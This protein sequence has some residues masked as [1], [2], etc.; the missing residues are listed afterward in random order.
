MEPRLQPGFPPIAE[1]DQTGAWT[2]YIYANGRKI[3]RV[4]PTTHRIHVHGT[5]VQS[6]YELVV[7]I[8]PPANFVV[9]PG[10]TV[11][12]QQFDGGDV[13][14]INL[15]FSSTQTAWHSQDYAGEDFNQDFD[16]GGWY[17]RCGSLN[18]FVGQT[19]V[20]AQVNKDVATQPGTWDMLIADWSIFRVDGT[21][22]PIF[23][24][25]NP[26]AG[27]MAVD[28]DYDTAFTAAVEDS[29]AATDPL[30]PPASSAWAATHFYTGDHLGT[31]QLE[32]SSGGWPVWQ[33]HFAPYGQELLSGGAPLAPDLP[34]GSNNHYKFTGK[35]RDAESGLDN[36]ISRYYGSN[37]GRFMSPDDG[38][39]Q[40]TVNP[41]SWNLYSYGRN[42]PL[43]GID[44]DGHTYN[45]CSADGK[46][47]SNVS[48][49]DF[50]ADQKKDQA[51][52]VNFSK[53]TITDSNG[54]KQGSYTHDPDIAGDPATNIAAMGRIA[55]DGNGAIK[56]FVVG[57]V[58][59]GGTAGVGL[60]ASGAGAGLTTLGDLS[61]NILT[62]QQAGAIIGW[63]TGQ[64][65]AG[66]LA[67]QELAANLTAEDVAGM[68]AKG[69]NPA[70]AQKL[71]NVYERAVT[72]G[73]AGG[74]AMARR[75]LM[76]KI[77]Q[78]MGK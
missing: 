16:Q 35:E 74:Q 42:N 27:L 1:R 46:S 51:N 13:G 57:S 28:T 44:A 24:A 11:C 2:D 59:I 50:E 17:S 18:D 62:N 34:D 26:I 47:C 22:V 37:M 60:Y 30:A 21:V 10:D 52:G 77:V 45:V 31:A 58:A 68:E 25:G 53:G 4:A 15:G 14:G 48:D 6:G 3:A 66:V 12:W 7:S 33:G 43:I 69:L 61:L 73:K 71:L 5:T 65:E 56:A 36:F 63:G 20:Y 64:A 9:Q 55:R 29:P 49:K 72:A 67:T 8:Q 32:L 40:D 41:Q 54:V 39:D 23:T 70:T 19:M 76:I 78:L 38:E 75:E